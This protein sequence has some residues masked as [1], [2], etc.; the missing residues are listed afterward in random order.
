LINHSVRTF[1]LG[2]AYAA[3]KRMVLEDEEALMLA[4]LFHDLG[5]CPA[6]SKR[7]S[8][9][10]KQSSAHAR[11]VLAAGNVDP[12]R[13]SAISEAI[14]LHILLFPAWSHGQVAG[15]LHVGAWMDLF[16][17]KRWSLRKEAR[18]ILK[19]YPREGLAVAFPR[20]LVSSFVMGSN[21]RR[22]RT[23]R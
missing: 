4:S 3:K 16:C 2:R 12:A 23:R 17:R 8:L 13:A 7:W 14:E 15:L 10:V 9:F 19:A 5:I 20:Y 11:N 22:D 1:L 21:G 18:A 6:A